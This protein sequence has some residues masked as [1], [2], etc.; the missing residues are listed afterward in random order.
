MAQCF[1]DTT[2]CLHMWVLRGCGS[3]RPGK[4]QASQNA[5]G[6][7]WAQSPKATDNW[8]LTGEGDSISFLRLYP[9]S[10]RQSYIP[11]SM[12]NDK[13]TC[14]CS[15]KWGR[16]TIVFSLEYIYLWRYLFKHI[17]SIMMSG[18]VF[19]QGRW[20][21][22]TLVFFIGIYISGDIFLNTLFLCIF[23]NHPRYKYN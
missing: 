7:K 3:T 11:T 22:H 2:W 10:N 12:G 23:M 16:H 18:L 20:G 21:W 19:V 15:G 13:W 1:R 6:E 5:R 14:V 17:I 8:W 9:C 4:D